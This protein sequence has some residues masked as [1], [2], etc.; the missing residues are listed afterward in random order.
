LT[1][2]TTKLDEASQA[3]DESERKRAI[4]DGKVTGFGNRYDTLEQLVKE[5]KQLGH[6]NERKYEEVA[7]VSNRTCHKLTKLHS[8]IAS[9]LTWGKNTSSSSSS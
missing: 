2:A 4:L 3:A 6:L 8:S 9:L 5:A 1:Q 7:K